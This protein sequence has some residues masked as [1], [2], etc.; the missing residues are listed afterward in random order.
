VPGRKDPARP[1]LPAELRQA[2]PRQVRASLAGVGVLLV[3]GALA[4]GAVGVGPWLYSRAKASQQ[5][6]EIVVSSGVA[7]TAEVVQT[8]WRGSG[9]DR[10]RVIHYRYAAGQSDHRGATALR[11]ADRDR[12][13]RGS[14]VAIHY[15]KSDPSTS[16]TDGYE[17][18]S[19]PEWPAYAIPAAMI[20]SALILVRLFL[21]Q[22]QLLAEGRPALAVIT[23]VEKKRSSH[24]GS[25]RVHF[26]WTLLSGARATGQYE[27][28]RTPPDV[29]ATIPIVYDRD[30]MRRYWK[31]PLPLVSVRKHL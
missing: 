5:L 14:R 15:L 9:G 7:T 19:R 4:M 16:W 12:Y 17:P 2:V 22:S 27:R 20:L 10:R 28:K 26:D 24:G 31:Y 1:S 18:R 13:E 29:G 21:S 30:N 25:W 11:R 8:E 6:A 23:K 3:V